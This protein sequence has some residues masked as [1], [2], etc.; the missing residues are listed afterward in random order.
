MEGHVLQEFG[1]L[2]QIGGEDFD[3]DGEA[4][5]AEFLHQV[6]AETFDFF[7]E[8]GGGAFGGA[9]VE[10]AGEKGAEAA[11]FGGLG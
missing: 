1:G 6:A 8:L 2:V 11:G 4:V 7:G 3:G 10:H 9:F 5:V